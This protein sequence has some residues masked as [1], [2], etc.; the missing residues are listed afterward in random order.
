MHSVKDSFEP[1]PLN[2][3][4]TEEFTMDELACIIEGK[5]IPARTEDAN[6]NLRNS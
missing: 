1:V 3:E 2:L 6:N 5:P 4:T